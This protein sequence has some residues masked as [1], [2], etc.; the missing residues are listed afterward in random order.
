MDQTPCKIRQIG[1]PLLGAYFGLI[2]DFMLDLN[3]G[4]DFVSYFGFHLG[5]ILVPKPHKMRVQQEIHRR[6]VC[7]G[8]ECVILRSFLDTFLD[9][10]RRVSGQDGNRKK[11]IYLIGTK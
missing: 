8:L 6:L 4:I 10:F 2:V 1:T 11:H 3:F 7:D 5:P 9:A